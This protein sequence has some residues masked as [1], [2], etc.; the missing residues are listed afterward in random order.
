MAGADYRVTPDTLL[1]F[2]LAGGTTGFSLASGLGIGSADLFQAGAFARHDLGPGYLSAALAYG[3]HDV[4]TDRS[5]ALA[6][7]DRLQ[8]CFKADTLSGR[9]E[10]GYRFATLWA[11]LTPYAAAQVISFRLP[12]YAEQ[13]LA[14]TGL[15]ALNYG[16][17][18]TTSTRTELGLRGDRSFATQTGVLTLLSRLAWAHD[19]D[20]SRG[21]TAAFQA[22][23]GTS[24]VVNG[25][26][27]NADSALVST[28]AD[29]KWSNGFSLATTFEGEFACHVTS[30][31][32]KGVARYTW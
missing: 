15:F 26:R 8:G 27:P 30:Y 4:T 31:A 24:F 16:A 2:A 10:G 13:T 9:F 21:V 19:Y 25:A 1:G 5:V 7:V 17:E 18:T 32:G 23:P 6:G 3:W 12:A 11:G 22:L 29:M 14:G 28:G 20:T